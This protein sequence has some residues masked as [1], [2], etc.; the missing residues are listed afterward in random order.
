MS[1]AETFCEE[2]IAMKTSQRKIWVQVLFVFGLSAVLAACGQRGGSTSRSNVRAAGPGTHLNVSTQGF[3]SQCSNG[4]SA[5]GAIFDGGG[6]T[7]VGGSFR[8]RVGQLVSATMDPASF[9][10]I[11]G[12]YGAQTGIDLRLRLLALGTGQV[13]GQQ[14]RLQLVIYDSL[15]GQPKSSGG[16]IEPYPITITGSATGVINQATRQFQV[17][18]SDQYGTIQLSGTW[19]QNQASGTVVFQNRTHFSSGMPASGT[20]GNFV[21][22]ACAL[23]Q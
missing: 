23:F 13:D 9:G 15:V 19:D 2:I 22:P 21:F 16:T 3:M 7:T 4:T 6:T 1:L 5:V 18:F 14:S 20:L 17:S 10:D 12:Q 11:S 8:D